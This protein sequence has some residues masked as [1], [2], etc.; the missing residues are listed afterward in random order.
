MIFYGIIM[1]LF[2]DTTEQDIN[3]VKNDL[4]SKIKDEILLVPRI[5][6]GLFMEEDN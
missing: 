2:S 3:S 4:F 6:A 1:D 5:S